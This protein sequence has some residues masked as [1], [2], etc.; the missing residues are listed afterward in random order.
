[1]PLIHIQLAEGV[2]PD[3]L[4]YSLQVG[5]TL[6]YV[7]VS[8]LGGF[9]VG[10]QPDIVKIGTYLGQGTIYVYEG[11]EDDPIAY[12]APLG[13]IWVMVEDGDIA[14]NMFEG[15]PFENFLLFSKDNIVNEDGLLGYYMSVKIENDSDDYAELFSVGTEVFESSK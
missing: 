8:S 3:K 5:D 15:D 13:R 14:P 10:E 6:Y 12:Q 11:G 1:M 9:E 7:P 2:V 4:N